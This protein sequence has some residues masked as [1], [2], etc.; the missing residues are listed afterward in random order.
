MQFVHW[1]THEF[2]NEIDGEAMYRVIRDGMAA[3][4][5]AIRKDA[6]IRGYRDGKARRAIDKPL[7]DCINTEKEPRP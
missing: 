4:V 3:R 2:R 1:F 6:Y 7:Y 5:L